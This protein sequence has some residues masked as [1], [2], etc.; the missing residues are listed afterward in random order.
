MGYRKQPTGRQRRRVWMRRMGYRRAAEG[1]RP[2]VLSSYD[3]R[4]PWESPPPKSLSCR[5]F[6]KHYLNW[7][8]L[9]PLGTRQTLMSFFPALCTPPAHCKQIREGPLHADQGGTIACR[10][11]REYCMQIREG[12]LY[13]D[14]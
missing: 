3:W 6:L 7:D 10:S 9:D 4:E 8:S 11:G 1:K 12:P 14:Q 2:D 13:A 5:H